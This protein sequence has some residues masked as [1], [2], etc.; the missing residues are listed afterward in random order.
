MLSWHVQNF[1]VIWYPA[2]ELQEN[3][4]SI[5]FELQWE[6]SLWNEL[7]VVHLATDLLQTA[8]NPGWGYHACLEAMPYLLI[9]VTGSPYKIYLC[10]V[11]NQSKTD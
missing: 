2:T 7:K 4:F 6:N 1:V 5:E 8:S 10:S 3:N 9:I 11:H